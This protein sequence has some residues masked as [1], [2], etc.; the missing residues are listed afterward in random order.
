MNDKAG[1]QKH[2]LFDMSNTILLID[3][4]AVF[5]FIAESHI[6]RID[7]S[8]Q[9]FTVFNGKDALAF[10]DDAFKL[11]KEKPTHIFVDLNMPVMDGFVFL[12]EFRKLAPNDTSGIKVFVLTTSVNP[13]DK[14]RAT[15]YGIDGYISKPLSTEFLKSILYL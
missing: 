4:E 11:L 12:E 10:L 3:D 1:R 13:L 5:N 15:S 9:I 7:P 2:N 8:C 14:A 6:K